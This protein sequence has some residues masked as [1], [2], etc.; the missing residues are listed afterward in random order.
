MPSILFINRVYPPDEGATGRVLE[1]LCRGLVAK[2]WTVSV[3]VTAGGRSSAGLSF[4][5]GVA[6]HR[7]G[8][9][10]SKKNLLLRA[11]GYALMIPS[12]FF[13]SLFL[14]RADV[15]V[16]MTDPPMLLVIGPLI[17]LFKGSRLVHWA[18]DL[19]PE[20]AEE[21][22]VFPKGGLAARVLTFLS[23]S[24]MRAHD[25]TVAL[26]RCMRKRLLKRGLRDDQIRVIPNTGVEQEIAVV[27]REDRGFRDRNGLGDDF[28]IE[29]SGN[30][31]RAHEFETVLDAAV[32]L[33][34]LGVTGITFLFVGNGPR[35]A[36]LKEEVAQRN[37]Q[38]VKFLP[39]QSSAVL[40]ESL[41]AADLHLVT[42]RPRMEGLVVP[43][44]FYGVMASARPCLFV[45]SLE[46]EIAQVI[47]ELGIG[48]VTLPG[49]SQRM[50]SVIQAYRGSCERGRD[51][52]LRARDS[53]R[54]Q[55]ATELFLKT[56]SEML[57]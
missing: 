25:R 28:I 20:V 22:G 15:V 41:A 11:F 6:I 9:A 7:I 23:S 57:A 29:Y 31:G 17:R 30:M 34:D 19:Y 2:G 5:D 35:E 32:K 26:G 44:K 21:L 36:W 56:V 47:L 24:T 53:V 51:E 45:G 13:K 14:P 43:S 10:F 3:L 55:N 1:Y 4:K 27:P 48:E 46:S 18:Q 40:G 39:G 33:Q 50:V 54:S 8:G 37:L 49:E 38:N 16:T 12:F 42:M 52:G